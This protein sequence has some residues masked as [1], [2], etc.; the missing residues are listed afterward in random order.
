MT[1]SEVLSN[2]DEKL[3]HLSE[4]Q[5]EAME[6]L[7]LRYEEVFPDV[8]RR[9]NVMVHDVDV[10]D[11]R[12]IKQHPYR[13]NPEKGKLAEKEIRVYVDKWYYPTI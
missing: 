4:E 11:T 8:P 13:M 10:G 1:N 7:L 12:P 5:C 2:L 3:A 9:T 6:A